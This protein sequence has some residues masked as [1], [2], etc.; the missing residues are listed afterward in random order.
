M[1]PW[2][3]L[4]DSAQLQPDACRGENEWEGCNTA[5]NMVFHLLAL[6]AMHVPQLT[7]SP[8][9]QE[10]TAL[11]GIYSSWCHDGQLPWHGYRSRERPDPRVCVY[12]HTREQ[13]LARTKHAGPP[14]EWRSSHRSGTSNSATTAVPKAVVWFTLFEEG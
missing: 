1:R 8:A 13:V 11:H 3:E 7:I 14:N 12:N 9:I 5:S 10:E 6:C 2:T 4:R